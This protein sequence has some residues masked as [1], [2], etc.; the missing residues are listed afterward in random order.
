MAF[1]V[2]TRRGKFE[3]R[4][5]RSTPKGPRARTLA[6]FGELSDQIIEKAQSRAAK[7]LDPDLLR[8]AARR[9]GAPVEPTPA[10][11]AAREMISELGRGG[12][13]QPK[14]R[15][16]LSSMLDDGNHR[17]TSPADPGQ[18]VAEWMAA[19]PDERARS[20]VDLLLLGDAL[21]HGGRRGKPLEFPR[22]ESAPS[23]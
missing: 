9:V 23:A 1:I 4:E 15:R 19:T 12:Q 8:E 22:L 2:P 14:L 18:A 11:R 20:L 10:D 7:Q 13:P 5:S 3:L 6:T 21:P 17:A 16:L